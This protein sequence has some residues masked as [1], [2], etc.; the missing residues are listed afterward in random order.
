MAYQSLSFVSTVV[1]LAARVTCQEWVVKTLV[2]GASFAGA[3]PAV[4]ALERRRDGQGA[5]PP[6]DVQSTDNSAMAYLMLPRRGI[7]YFSASC[8]KS[9]NRVQRVS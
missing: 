1:L 9:A 2:L 8:S 7:G 3:G 6:S 4:L 5:A